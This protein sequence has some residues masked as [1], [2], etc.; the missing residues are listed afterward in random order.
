MLAAI[1]RRAAHVWRQPTAVRLDM[2]LA[3]HEPACS[4]Q[5]EHCP[6]LSQTGRTRG[7]LTTSVRPL[8]L[9]HADVGVRPGE[10]AALGQQRPV[11]D[12]GP[13]AVGHRRAAFRRTAPRTNSVRGRWRSNPPPAVRR[14]RASD[15]QHA[16]AERRRHIIRCWPAMACGRRASAL[17]R[18]GYRAC[19][20]KPMSSKPDR[21]AVQNPVGHG[22]VHQCAWDLTRPVPRQTHP[23]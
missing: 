7:T 19:N 6:C 12:G 1:I 17:L 14:R 18:P 23:R 22:P 21:V 13:G 20:R 8:A 11:H 9:H 15:V 2:Q 4:W 10:P 5:L 3:R 16:V